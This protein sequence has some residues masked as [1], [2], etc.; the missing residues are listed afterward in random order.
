MAHAFTYRTDSSGSYVG[1]T[2]AKPTAWFQLHPRNWTNP[3]GK[4]TGFYG[5][6]KE[7]LD[8]L[9]GFDGELWL[10]AEDPDVPNGKAYPLAD[11][12]A[13]AGRTY[14]TSTFSY[15]LGMIW[16][17]HVHM[18]RPVEKVVDVD[19]IRGSEATAWA[20]TESLSH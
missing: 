20:M 15:Q 17:Q 4:Q 7:H 10:Q 3:A 8:F 18:N 2:K 9:K 11:I 6:P 13:K 1:V 16:Y 14:F 12:A 19:Q 5:R